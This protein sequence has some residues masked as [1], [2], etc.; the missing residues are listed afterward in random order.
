MKKA[1]HCTEREIIK[2]D[3]EGKHKKEYERNSEV[4][5]VI[6]SGRENRGRGWM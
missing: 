4:T 3:H 1:K 6:G 2:Q 5:C